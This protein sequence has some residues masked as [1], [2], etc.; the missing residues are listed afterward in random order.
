VLVKEII[1][2]EK[3]LTE[4]GTPA[5]TVEYLF[6]AMTENTTYAVIRNYDFNL[7]GN[8]LIRQLKTIQAVFQ[9]C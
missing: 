7:E 2:N 9:L 8:D 3:I 5:T 6:N 1:L 4:W